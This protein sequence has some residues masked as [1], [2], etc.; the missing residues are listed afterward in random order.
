MILDTRSPEKFSNCHIPNSIFIGI[1]GSFAPWVGE[2]L[3]N[4]KIKILI[5]VDD[6]RQTEV[7][8]RLSRVGFDNYIGYLSGG[9]KSWIK[10]GYETQT[11]ENISQM[12]LLK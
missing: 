3:K 2:I 10:N 12:N 5:V 4:I 6:G 8:T 1:D 11:I 7:F 9:I